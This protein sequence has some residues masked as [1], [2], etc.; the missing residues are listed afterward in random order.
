MKSEDGKVFLHVAKS[1]YRP[2]RSK[3]DTALEMLVDAENGDVAAFAWCAVGPQFS[4]WWSITATNRDT[5]MSLIGEL[6]MMIRILEDEELKSL[7]SR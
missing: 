1:P 3:I 5:R 2:H 6:Q 4:T 7:D